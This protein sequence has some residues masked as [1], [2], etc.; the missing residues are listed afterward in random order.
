MSKENKAR[1]EGKAIIIVIVVIIIAAIASGGYYF[2][3]KNK[4]KQ[5][6]V[7]YLNE[8]ASAFSE[9]VNKIND[10]DSE[11]ITE[12]SNPAEREQNLEKAKAELEKVAEVKK[13][14]EEAQKAA[15]VNSNKYVKELDQKVDE[16][17]KNSEE[18]LV[19]YEEI[20]NYDVKYSEN[21]EAFIEALN[22]YF[23]LMM[24]LEQ[25]PNSVNED[26]LITSIKNIDDAINTS[27]EAVK[28]ME[29]PES[30]KDIHEKTIAL[31]E[32]YKKASNDLDAVIQNEESAIIESKFQEFNLALL[33][34]EQSNAIKELLDEKL[35]TY[36]EDFGSINDKANELKN[37]MKSVAAE[38]DT[39][40]DVGEIEKW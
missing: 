2:Y 13:E 27:S 29:A 4:T 17:Y 20:L 10:L 36:E 23:S 40:V 14:L 28:Q 11:N 16:F 33:D 8:E 32:S 3:S 1:Q 30:I 25:D 37:E 5:D 26:Q 38:L 12:E 31:M 15:N 24:S 9:V 7:A 34:E 22:G 18:L 39:Q 21:Q 35:E 19:K 6:A